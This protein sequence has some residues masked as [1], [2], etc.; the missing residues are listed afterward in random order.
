MT[1]KTLAI[2]LSICLY[3][4]AQA[5]EPE[6]YSD[7]KSPPPIAMPEN[8]PYLWVGRTGKRTYQLSLEQMRR[9]NLQPGDSVDPG[10]LM[11]IIEGESE[12]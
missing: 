5:D 4:N 2:F 7:W 8:A 9:Y 10:V 12:Q 11:L 1:Q 3:G 6:G